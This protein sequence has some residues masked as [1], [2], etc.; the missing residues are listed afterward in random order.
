MDRRRFFAG[1]GALGAAAA[2]PG[3]RRTD[4]CTTTSNPEHGHAGPTAAGH[5]E[6]DETQ[7]PASADDR[8]AA[9]AGFC[10]GVQPIAT[11]EY[12]QRI[13]RVRAR[14]TDARQAALI[15][16]AGVDM[17]YFGGP[18]WGLSERPLLLVIPRVGEPTLHGPAFEHG[19]LEARQ[20]ALR[21]AIR[22]WH[23]HESPYAVVRKT[24]DDAR[25][26]RRET[27]AIGPTMRSFVADGL[28]SDGGCT[29]GS[30]AAAIESCRRIKSSAELALLRR[31]NEATK[32]ALAAAAPLARAGMS[33]AELADVIRSAQRAAGLDNVWVLALFGP[34][35]AYPH[36]TPEGRTLAEGDLILVDTGGFLHGYASDITRTWAFP[37]V[38]AIDEPRRKAWAVVHQAQTAALEQIRP[39]VRCAEVDAAAREVVAKAGFDPDYGVFTHRLGHGIGMEV[40]EA[41]YLVRDAEHRL[42]VGN[43]MSNEPGIYVP[44]G[45]GIRLEDIVAVGED[46]PEVFGPRAGSLELPF[47]SRSL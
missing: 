32:V 37:S 3:C 24:L 11:A 9:L 13:E 44:G 19:T 34:N 47:G 17:R 22:T 27:V 8:F 5:G 42:E 16:E 1:L 4:E 12:E 46:G 43:T 35:A 14:L 21:L 18:A 26:G 33:E 23:E 2:L 30:G 39:G 6:A 40:H 7:A 29:L 36:G 38:E 25:L 10:A 31:A 28:R 45:F 41:P 15:V 20:G